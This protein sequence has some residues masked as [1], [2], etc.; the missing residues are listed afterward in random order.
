MLETASTISQG[1]LLLLC[2]IVLGAF[3]LLIAYALHDALR[4][5]R[6][7]TGRERRR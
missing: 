1:A 2:C 7:G 3:I 5:W 4:D 6:N